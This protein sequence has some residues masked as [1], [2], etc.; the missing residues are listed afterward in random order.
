MGIVGRMVPVKDHAT[1]VAAAAVLASRRPDMRFVF[2][3][4]GELETAVRDQIR[5]AGLGRGPT[6]WGGAGISQ[7]STLT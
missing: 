5:R 1:F 4:G 6:F 7:E 3:G 2:V